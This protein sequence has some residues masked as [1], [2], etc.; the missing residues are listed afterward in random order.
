MLADA[1]VYEPLNKNPLATEQPRCNKELSRIFSGMGMSVQPIPFKIILPVLAYCYFSPK[2]HKDPISYRPIVSQRQAFTARLARHLSSI[3]TPT[4]GSFSPAHLR[5]ST[6]LKA[7]LLEK[8]DPSLPFISLDVDALFTNVPLEPLL[9]F[10]HR[11]HDQ[12]G[13]PLPPGYTILGFLDLIRLC[14]G[15]S[16]FSFNGKFYKQKQGVT[17]GSPLAPA[18]ACLYME[19]FETELRKRIP[20]PN[21][22]L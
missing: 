2:L 16:V 14:V 11:K 20:G 21:L 4:L 7:M 12:G 10:L 15:S 22:T 19:F 13:L 1:D 3:L 5:D 18:M 6:H 9:G 8:A 17:M